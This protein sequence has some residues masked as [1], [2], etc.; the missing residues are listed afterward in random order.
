[1]CFFSKDELELMGI[2]IKCTADQSSYFHGIVSVNRD[3][4]FDEMGQGTNNIW[5]GICIFFPCFPSQF[6]LNKG[7]TLYFG[8]LSFGNMGSLES[9]LVLSL[10]WLV[11]IFTMAVD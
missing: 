3:A 4:F 5:A 6:S 11:C 10:L 7:Q 2:Y 8:Y 9:K 1:M